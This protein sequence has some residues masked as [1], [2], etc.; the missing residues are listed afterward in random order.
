MPAT[1]ITM[2]ERTAARRLGAVLALLAAPFA[3]ADSSLRVEVAGLRQAV[4]D[5]RVALYRDPGSFRREAEALQVHVEPAQ[6]D[7]QTVL[8]SGLTPGSYALVAYHDVNGDGQL[9]LRFGMFPLEPYGLSNNPQ[10]IGPPRFAD[11]A[12]ELG[13]GERQIEI[14]LR[15]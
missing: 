10:L 11:S 3:H 12:L 15:D 6:A 1:T 13:D 8:F 2:T 14:N 9:N 5:L 4:G 7:R